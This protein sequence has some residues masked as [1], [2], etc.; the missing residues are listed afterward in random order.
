MSAEAMGIK[1][2][3]AS[4]LAPTLDL[5]RTHILCSLKIKCGSELARDSSSVDAEEFQP[6]G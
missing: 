6:S 4:K 5:R 3:I 2:A 1:D